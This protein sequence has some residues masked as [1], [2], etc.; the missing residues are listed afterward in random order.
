MAK[1]I[2]V[3]GG[4]GFI[5]RNIVRRLNHLGHKV[6]VL[7]RSG[8]TAAALS[9]HFETIELVYGDFMDEHIVESSLKDID[10]VYHLITTTFPSTSIHSGV[11]DIQSNLIPTVRLIEL[12][13]REGVGRVIYLSSGGTIY[14]EQD[15]LPIEEDAQL[16]PISIYGQSK[17]IVESYLDFFRANSDLS[18]NILRASNPFGPEQ[19]PH[20]V[21]GLVPIA[22]DHLLSERS[23]PVIGD[24]KSV[25]DYLYIDD[26]IDALVLALD[27]RRNSTLNISSGVGTSITDLIEL[28]EQTTSRSLK[29]HHLPER[30]DYVKNSILSNRK[31][32]EVMHWYPKTSLR[33]GLEK[34]W[35][36]A[37][38]SEEKGH[39]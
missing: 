30:N 21:Q 11:Y 38:R 25:R 16:R 3:L 8:R 10:V 12:C 18:I 37:V 39:L 13:L 31:A 7:T 1:N 9:K 26:L 29:H 20:G 32:A 15:S 6:R 35:Q 17:K 24:G 36:T 4:T 34:T 14:G 19:S 33:V 22:I 2:L 23:L 28:L 27:A 5:G